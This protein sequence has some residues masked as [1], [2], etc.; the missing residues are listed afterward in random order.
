M[1]RGEV[2]A[3]RLD[4]ERPATSAIRTG[5][6]GSRW[7]P[8]RPCRSISPG[9]SSP[10]TAPAIGRAVRLTFDR[11]GPLVTSGSP[12]PAAARCRRA[13]TRTVAGRG[14]RVI[15]ASA[16]SSRE[17]HDRPVRG[18]GGVIYCASAGPSARRRRR[19]RPNR[20]RRC[21]RLAGSYRGAVQLHGDRADGGRPWPRPFA[22][23]ARRFWPMWLRNRAPPRREPAAGVG[24]GQHGQL[25]DQQADGGKTGMSSNSRFPRTWRDRYSRS[26]LQGCRT[27]QKTLAWPTRCLSLWFFRKADV[28]QVWREIRNAEPWAVAAL[29]GVTGLIFPRALRWQFLLRPIGPTRLSGRSG[30]TV[31]A[32]PPTPCCRCGREMVGRICWRH[33]LSVP[34][35]SPLSSNGSS[36]S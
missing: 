7:P 34:A 31:S 14:R 6:C 35:T 17:L 27:H 10:V 11:T 26:R 21:R 33:G 30:T 32:L 25:I 23:A 18:D 29:L 1:P 12:P 5:C 20:P 4:L 9:P 13:G 3:S 36:T 24:R 28:V 2:A 19:R 15:P 22:H 16:G 8:I